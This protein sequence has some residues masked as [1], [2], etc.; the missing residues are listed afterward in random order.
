MGNSEQPKRNSKML[1]LTSSREQKRKRTS[2]E[3]AAGDTEKLLELLIAQLVAQNINR[4]LDRDQR[5]DE[6]NSLL[7]VLNKIAEALG[8]IA[9]K[10]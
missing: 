6:A 8:R 2:Q 10:L 4:Q 1:K 7:G 5:E 3:G 9:D